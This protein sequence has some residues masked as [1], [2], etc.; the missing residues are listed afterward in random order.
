V[1]DG[2]DDIVWKKTVVSGE[3]EELVKFRILTVAFEPPP[4]SLSTPNQYL[5]PFS[6]EI[7]LPLLR[8]QALFHPAEFLSVR[9]G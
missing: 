9:L 2:D 7:K 6:Y 8:Q 3:I 1:T 4:P 5:T